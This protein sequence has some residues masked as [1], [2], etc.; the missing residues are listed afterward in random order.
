MK[1]LFVTNLPSPYRVEF[2]NQLGQACDLT[3][4]YERDSASDRDKDWVN[5]SN[6]SYKTIFLK[7]RKIGADK[8]IGFGLIKYLKNSD[9]DRIVFCGYS[10]PATIMGISYCRRHK[11][12]YYIE[13]DGGLGNNEK[14]VKRYL[15]RY[16]TGKCEG[17]LTT[18][19]TDVSN[20]ESLGVDKSKIYKYPFSSL[21]DSDIIDRRVTEEEKTALRNKLG[22]KGGKIVISVGRFI[23]VKGFD[24]LLEAAKSFDSDISLYIVGGK[25]TGE[26]LELS[27][28]LNS[29]GFF[30]FMSFEE[31]KK[32]Y[33]AS[34]LFVLATRGDVWG[35]VV[36]EAMAN[37]LPVVTTYTCGAGLEM[38]NNGKNGMLVKTD[39]AG[40]LAK[41]V[42]YCLSDTQLTEQ[43]SQNALQTAKKYTIEKMVGEH[44]R[45]LSL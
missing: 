2:F 31:L 9:Y 24:T 4:I 17:I 32:Y 41:A 13:S 3:V 18:C 42:N 21:K 22:I 8:S 43:L 33:Q 1:V 36:N 5:Q 45:I 14:S 40:A 15:K 7:N 23:P 34:D 6:G 29:V 39:D 12:P 26:Y 11:I 35:L 44:L 25:P 19:D 37:G 16:L 38:V 20:F 27:K 28:G 30:D 10:S